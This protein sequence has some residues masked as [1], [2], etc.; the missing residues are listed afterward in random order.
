MSGG[1][2][3]RKKPSTSHPQKAAEKSDQ[4]TQVFVLEST[5]TKSNMAAIFDE[6]RS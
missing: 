3:H 2:D 1:A 6:W 4:S 5:E